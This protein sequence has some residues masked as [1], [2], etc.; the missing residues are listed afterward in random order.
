MLLPC[1][2]TG[3]QPF[4]FASLQPFGVYPWKVEV[5]PGAGLCPMPEVHQVA[6]PSTVSS[7]GEP[8][9]T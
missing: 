3:A 2:Q 9:A 7:S 8:H 6:V 4:A 5:P 1:S